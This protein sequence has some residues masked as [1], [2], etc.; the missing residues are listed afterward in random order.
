MTPSYAAMFTHA[1]T[2]LS[3]SLSRTLKKVGGG[4]S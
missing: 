3:L 1:T 2:A 4:E